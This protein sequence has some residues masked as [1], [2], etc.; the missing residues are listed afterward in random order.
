MEVKIREGRLMLTSSYETTFLK[1]GSTNANLLGFTNLTTDLTSTLPYTIKADQVGSVVT[2]GSPN[3]PN[4]KLYIAGKV[5]G[6]KAINLNS[7]K[8]PDGI[9]IDLD[10]TGLLE[11]RDGSIQMNVGTYGIVKGDII[12]GGAGSDIILTAEN[13]L[14]LHGSLTANDQV[15]LSAGKNVVAGQTVFT[16]RHQ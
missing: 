13:T 8:S 12:A 4:G 6:Y 3:G 14:E 5:L 9:D 11:T 2:I 1:T 10:G 7:G 15:S 16:P